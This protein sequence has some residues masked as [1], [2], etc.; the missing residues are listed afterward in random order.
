V[1]NVNILATAEPGT[2]NP[3]PDIHSTERKE[4]MENRKQ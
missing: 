3:E 1:C 2:V 4:V